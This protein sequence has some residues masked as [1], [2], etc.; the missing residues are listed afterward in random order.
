MNDFTV[1]FIR[2]GVFGSLHHLSEG[3]RREEYFQ[4]C[5]RTNKM[6]F[7]IQTFVADSVSSKSLI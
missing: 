1:S 3:K 2:T 7:F 6:S 4:F 5:E